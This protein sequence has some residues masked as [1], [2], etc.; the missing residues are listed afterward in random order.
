MD[1]VDLLGVREFFFHPVRRL[2]AFQI[3]VCSDV[4]DDEVVI[5]DVDHSVDDYDRYACFFC[6]LKDR[7]PAFLRYR[8]N[9]YIIDLLLYELSY[10]TK[11]ILLH[12]LGVVE[13]HPVPVLFR[14]HCVD[15][16]RVCDPPVGFRSDLRYAYDDEV[17]LARRL[18]CVARTHKAAAKHGSKQNCYYLLQHVIHSPWMRGSLR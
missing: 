5:R 15:R 3:E 18:V 17:I 13:E 4:R 16:L 14:E 2:L 9:D 1:D 10:R 12:L 6:L 8:H 7:V 11:L